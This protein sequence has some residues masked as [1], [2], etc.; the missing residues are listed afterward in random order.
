MMDIKE[1]LLQLFVHFLIKKT[2]GIG[3][4]NDIRSDQQLAEELLK[5]IIKKFKK[6][7][8]QLTFKDNIWSVDLT[9]MQLISNFNIE[10]RIFIICY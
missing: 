6:R 4:K 9:D 2:C 10:F 5:P 3:I 7:K 8:L 1:V